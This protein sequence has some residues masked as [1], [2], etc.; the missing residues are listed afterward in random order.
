MAAGEFDRDDDPG[1]GV[2]GPARPG[3]SGGEVEVTVPA[4]GTLIQ[5]P[6]VAA[7][8]RIEVA[9]GQPVL[10]GQPL[11]MMEA[12]KMETVVRAPCDGIVDQVLVGTGAQVLAGEALLVLAGAADLAEVAA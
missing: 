9:P 10:A 7:L 12:M 6:F 4:G 11:L 1:A 3:A 2:S 5:A 8:W